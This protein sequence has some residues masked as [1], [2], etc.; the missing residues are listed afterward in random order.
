[1]YISIIQRRKLNRMK[2]TRARVQPSALHLL[3]MS[4]LCENAGHYP[5]FICVSLQSIEVAQKYKQ[6]RIEYRIEIWFE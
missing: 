1:M 2:N 3:K 4:I 6:R 5:N